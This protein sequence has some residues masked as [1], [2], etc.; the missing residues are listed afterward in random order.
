MHPASPL[1][2]AGAPFIPAAFKSHPP[3]LVVTLGTLAAVSVTLL[4]TGISLRLAEPPPAAVPLMLLLAVGCPLTIAPPILWVLARLI[5]RLEAQRR[6]LTR[7]ND[8]L[9]HALGEVRELS[10]LLPIC[11]WCKRVRE[12]D[13]YW[14]QLE[15]YLGNHTRA[16]ITHGICPDCAKKLAG[17]LIPRPDAA[18][19]DEA[20]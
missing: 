17:E 16:E 7:T 1:S 9:S 11:A 5:A 15:R 12:D 8:E 19:K 10:G 6:E 3:W 4:F 14:M 13:G 20:S 2:P 18:P